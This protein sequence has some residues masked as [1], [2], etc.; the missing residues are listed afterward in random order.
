MFL[1]EV[2]FFLIGAAWLL[3]LAANVRRSARDAR[4]MLLQA[5]MHTNAHRACRRI[6]LDEYGEPDECILE[7]G[8]IDPCVAGTSAFI[9]TGFH[10][11]PF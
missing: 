6:V 8:H 7:A 1:L 5:I 9:P 4:R 3:T 11:A 10:K 2:L